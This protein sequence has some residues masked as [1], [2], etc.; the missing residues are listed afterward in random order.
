M[1]DTLLAKG[2]SLWLNMFIAIWAIVYRDRIITLLKELFGS[3]GGKKPKDNDETE[4]DD[5]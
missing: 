4:K 2:I 3:Y 5:K 1:L